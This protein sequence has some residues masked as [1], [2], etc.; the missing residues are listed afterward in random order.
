MTI[1][2]LKSKSIVITGAAGF[3]GSNVLR[4]LN[5]A[6]LENIIIVDK[7]EITEGKKNNLADLKY[8]QYLDSADFLA[9]IEH[10]E[11]KDIGAIVHIGASVDTTD[12]DSVGL[13][14]NNTENSRVLFNYCV[15]NNCRLI[16]ASSAATYGGG[17]KGY[18]DSE[19]N[20]KPM[21][22][23]AESKYLFDE[24]VLDAAVKPGQWVGLKFFN[25]YGPGEAHK[26]Q[27]ASMVYH[28]YN[29]IR[30]TG[31]AELFKSYRAGYVHGEQKRDFVYVKD[32]AKVILFFLNHPDKSG[33]FN[34]GTG[35][36]RTFNDLARAV[37]AALGKP[38]AIK[39]AEMPPGLEGQ[40]QYFTQADIS[41]LRSAGYGEKFYTLEE[42]VSDYVNWLRK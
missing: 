37:F 9:K 7:G 16:Y 17:E 30:A 36:A 6:G 11:I 15:R 41:K 32:I 21:N 39:Y 40:Y 1:E 4:A 10:D 19:R 42:G 38:P 12:K 27:M 23:Y 8:A 2:N 22:P 25:V 26:G 20:L 3:I 33:I 5:E 28:L 13:M 29:K 34:L 31:E 24:F 35:Q 14:K 18:N